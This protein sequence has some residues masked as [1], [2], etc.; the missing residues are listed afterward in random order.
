VIGDWL[1]LVVNFWCDPHRAE[2]H[3][4]PTVARYCRG[5]SSRDV[6]DARGIAKST[7]LNP[8]TA[9]ARD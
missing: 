1:C 4:R 9:A 2:D 6:A 7:T 5:Q 3:R 8:Q